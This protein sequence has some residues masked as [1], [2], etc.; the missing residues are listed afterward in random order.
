MARLGTIHYAK[1][2]N[3]PRLQRLRDYLADGEWRTT[4]DIIVN[5]AVCAVN[6]AVCELRMNGYTIECRAVKGGGGIYEYRLVNGPERE[7]A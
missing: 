1:L 4:L 7:A 5:A 2:E 6:S 3:S